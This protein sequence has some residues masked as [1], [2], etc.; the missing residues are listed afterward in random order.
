MDFQSRHRRAALLSGASLWLLGSLTIAG[1]AAA[2]T[3]PSP[4]TAADRDASAHVSEIVVTAQF[5]GENLQKTPLAITAINAKM[6]EA[7]G[8]VNVTDIA[9]NAPNVTIESGDASFGPTPVVSIRGIGAH[10][11]TFASEPGVGVYIDDVYQST[12]LG[13]AIDL[14]DLDRVEISRGPQGTLSGKNAIGGT[15]KLY[16]KTPNGHSGDYIDT[17]YGSDNQFE[18]KAGAD[19]TLV[20]DRLF[21]AGAVSYHREDGYLNRLD[22]GCLHPGSGIAATT[23]APGCKLGEEGGYGHT[24][25]RLSLRWTPTPDLDVVL[26][27]DGQ[28]NRDQPVASRLIAA[29]NP[30][31]TP[32]TN[33]PLFITSNKFTNFSTYNTAEEDWSMPAINNVDAGGGELNIKY[34]LAPSMSLTSITAERGSNINFTSDGSAGPLTAVNEDNKISSRT[35]TQEVRV[36]TTVGNLNLTTGGYYLGFSGTLG[37]R[38]DLGYPAPIPGPPPPGGPPP[39]GTIGYTADDKVNGNTEAGFLHGVYH[40]TDKLNLTAGYR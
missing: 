28:S 19:V 37:G 31:G 39:M 40:V 9:A 25:G 1:A 16:S 18:V 10:D 38:F 11:F 20:P 4:K 21:L 24:A 35:F 22:Y 3:T 14:L 30:T 33:F 23:T 7:R 8:E 32:A 27:G 2:Q 15:I 6:L 26:T 29:R 17:G 36:N 5:R 13:S 34:R 12:L